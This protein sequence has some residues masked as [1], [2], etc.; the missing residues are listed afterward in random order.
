MQTL[1]PYSGLIFLHS[2]SLEILHLARRL[3]CLKEGKMWQYARSLLMPS[4]CTYLRLKLLIEEEKSLGKSSHKWSKEP[5][6]D[7]QKGLLV[8]CPL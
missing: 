8:V 7:M 2:I 3:A 4:Q 6:F 1:K 5:Y